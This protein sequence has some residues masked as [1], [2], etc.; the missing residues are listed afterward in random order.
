MYYIYT[1]IRCTIFI[2]FTCMEIYILYDHSINDIR[3]GHFY[4]FAI[5]NNAAKNI[6]VHISLCSHLSVASGTNYH[7][8]SWQIKVLIYL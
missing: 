5:V 2:L 3:V 8:C 1:C 7:K 4:C 6:L